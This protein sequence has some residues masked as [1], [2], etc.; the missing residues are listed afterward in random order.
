ME[1]EVVLG[2]LAIGL[3]AVAVLPVAD[4]IVALVA[5]ALSAWMAVG[6]ATAADAGVAATPFEVVAWACAGALFARAFSERTLAIGVPVLVGAIDLAAVGGV[7]GPVGSAAP[8]EFP[9]AGD[10]LSLALPGATLLSPTVAVVAVVYL[11]AAAVWTRRLAPDASPHWSV[12]G[13][14]AL[15]AVPAVGV[16]LASATDRAV[17]VVALVAV[18]ALVL[19]GLQ[20][21]AAR[22]AGP[23]DAHRTGPA[24]AAGP[25]D[26]PPSGTVS[27]PH[28]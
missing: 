14:V 18:V 20:L 24:V 28:D 2:A 8:T 11:A 1:T 25:R 9:G 6:I 12:G 13:P 17:P 22:G 3:L 10:P 4:A 5:L 21:R 23:T 19:Q 27:G 7:L 26:A 16:T 15:A